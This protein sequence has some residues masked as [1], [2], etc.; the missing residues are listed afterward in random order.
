MRDYTLFIPEYWAAAAAI[1]VITIDIMWP[2]MRRD[3]LAYIT[4]GAALIWG[5]LGLFYIGNDVK[6]FAGLLQVD[7]FTT[8][9]R[10]LGAGIVFVTA[11]LSAQHMQ[12]RARVLGEYYGLLLVAG[13]G[14]VGMAAARELLTAYI[15]LEILSFSLYILV[16]Y[17]RRDILSAEASLKYVLLGAFASAMLLYGIS[18]VYG[19][20]GSTYYDESQ[21]PSRAWMAIP[22]AQWSWA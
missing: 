16:G 18:L 9:F 10:L 4:A 6:S 17:L 19:L 20:T 2:Q 7:D 8:F 3:M 1:L 22:A 15:S 13:I 11:L 14:M 5:V 21:P 12:S